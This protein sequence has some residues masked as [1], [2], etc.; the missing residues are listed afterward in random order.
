MSS[1]YRIQTRSVD[2][3]PTALGWGGTLSLVIDRPVEGGGRGLGFN[4]GQLLNLA[5]AGCIS[6]DLYREAAKRGIGLTRVVVT[7]DSDYVGQPATS[8]AIEY[9]VEIEG[10]AERARLDELVAY[11]DEIAE[12]PSSIR[13]GTPV[14]RHPRPPG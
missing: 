1:S 7:V 5:V 6:N 12:I 2:G 3:G 14:R 4:G 8:T 13:N 9:T 11:V 10:D